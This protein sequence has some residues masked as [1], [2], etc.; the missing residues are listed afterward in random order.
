MSFTVC[1]IHVTGCHQ[2]FLWMLLYSP[3]SKAL[4]AIWCQLV[5]K[6]KMYGKNPQ[7]IVLGG[8]PRD[9]STGPILLFFYVEKVSQVKQEVF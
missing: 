4:I 8:S 6:R 1:R 5:R 9:F 7:N 2:T 3:C